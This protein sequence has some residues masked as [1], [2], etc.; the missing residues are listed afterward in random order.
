MTRR[1]HRHRN[2]KREE[3]PEQSTSFFKQHTHA[4]PVQAKSETPFF[5]AKLTVGPQGDKYEKEADAVANHVVNNTA[6]QQNAPAVQRKDISSIQRYLASSKEDEK[7]STNDERMRRD[8]EIQTKPDVQRM[9]IVG[10]KQEEEKQVQKKSQEEEKDE[11]KAASAT[12]RKPEGGAGTPA[13][14]PR[15]STRIEQATGKGKALPP[16][17]LDHMNTSFGVD[18][19]DVNIHTSEESA[20]MNKELHAQAFTHG[21]DI[22]FNKGKYDPDSTEGK[23]LLAHELTHVVQQSA[24]GDKKTK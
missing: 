18:F 10:G 15:L 2:P 11:I 9:G 23:K 5:Q 6:G 3:Q 7:L 4:T 17:A 24:E 12:Q 16:Q 14:S 21:K 13:A 22:Y 19:S 1:S 20:D 8:K